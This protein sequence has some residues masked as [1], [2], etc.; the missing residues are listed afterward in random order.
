MKIDFQCPLASCSWEISC[1]FPDA[2][3]IF[4]VF[5]LLQFYSNLSGLIL[6]PLVGIHWT[7]TR[8]ENCYLLLIL[9]N[10][11]AFYLTITLLLSHLLPSGTPVRHIEICLN[12]CMLKLFILFFYLLTELLISALFFYN[13][14]V[15]FLFFFL[16]CMVMFQRPLLHTRFNIT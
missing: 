12:R 10:Y 5:G 16:I 7:S 1:F 15:L 2:F 3:K 11:Q 6:F 14:K 9:K 13:L 4:S 8:Y